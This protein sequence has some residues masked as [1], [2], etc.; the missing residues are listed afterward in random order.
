M[1]EAIYYSNKSNALR[2]MVF[3]ILQLIIDGLSLTILAYCILHQYSQG[4]GD[5]TLSIINICPETCRLGL[6][7]VSI[8]VCCLGNYLVY[9]IY[10]RISLNY[11]ELGIV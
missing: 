4:G 8:S 5:L 10:W 9:T 1:L 2:S 11:S 6:L 3:V 7:I